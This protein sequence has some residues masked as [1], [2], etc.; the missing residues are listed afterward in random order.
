MV[1]WKVHEIS[2]KGEGQTTANVSFKSLPCEFFDNTGMGSN[3]SSSTLSFLIERSKSEMRLVSSAA[4]KREALIIR[5]KI[6][7]KEKL[8]INRMQD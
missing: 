7:V 5:S 6:F 3:S 8:N 4:C 2:K 1:L